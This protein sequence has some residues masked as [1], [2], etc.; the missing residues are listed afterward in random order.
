M[1]GIVRCS[2]IEISSVRERVHP[3]RALHAAPVSADLLKLVTLQEQA[4][5]RPSVCSLDGAVEP[6]PRWAAAVEPVATSLVSSWHEVRAWREVLVHMAGERFE[7]VH[8]HSFSAGMAAVRNC[9][10]VVY[11]IK[12]FVEQLALDASAYNGSEPPGPWISRSFRVA[13]QFVIS[14]AGALIIRAPDHIGGALERGAE[15][16]NVFLVPQDKHADQQEIARRYDE[17]YHHAISRRDTG[18]RI[19]MAISLTPVRASGSF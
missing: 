4:G 9:D 1:S 11:E 19:G 15:P 16:D 12:D 17:A 2:T 10:V 3:W 7:V 6:D 13:E 18:P 5:M 14:R 8:A